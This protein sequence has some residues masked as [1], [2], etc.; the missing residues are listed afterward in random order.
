VD[1]LNDMVAGVKARLGVHLCRG[2]NAGRWLAEGGYDQIS[3]Q[4]FSRASNC[5]VLLLEYDDPAREGG[6]EPLLDVPND[7]VVVLGLVS[8]KR[9]EL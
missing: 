7:K 3:A 1:I 6:F 5:D 9:S 4:F 8:T 2:N